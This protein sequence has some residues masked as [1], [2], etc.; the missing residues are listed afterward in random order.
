MNKVDYN[1]DTV[2][3]VKLNIQHLFQVF[4]QIMHG[5]TKYLN[6]FYQNKVNNKLH[7]L[8]I[9]TPIMIKFTGE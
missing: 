1:T 6:Y 5:G 9:Q 8:S 7:L 4:S 3:S 2:E